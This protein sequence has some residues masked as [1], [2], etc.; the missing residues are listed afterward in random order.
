MKKFSDL[1]EGNLIYIYQ[2]SRNRY[3]SETIVSVADQHT[4][5]T[6]N[7]KTIDPFDVNANII[8]TLEGF[9]CV[10]DD[11]DYIN[12]LILLAEYRYLD[13]DTEIELYECDSLEELAEQF[14]NDGLFGEIPDSIC[15]YIDYKTMAIDLS[16]DYTEITIDN[17]GY[18]YRIM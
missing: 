4:I 7:N 6:N 12:S 17:T 2:S 14:V 5:K 11:E 9:I 13:A 16:Y 8:T 18:C 3:V 10:V 15:K 1:Q